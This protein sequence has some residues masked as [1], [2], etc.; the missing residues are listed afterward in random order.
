MLKRLLSQEIK[1]V[2]KRNI[3]AG[4]KFSEMLSA[5]LRRCQNRTLDTATLVA[6][7]VKLAQSLKSEADRG[8][9]SGLDQNELAFYDALRTNESAVSL[10]EDDT[11][12]TIAHELTETVRRDAK[13]DWTIKEQLRG[14]LRTTIKRLL[15]RHGYPPDKEP[16]ATELIV[17]QAEVMG[18]SQNQ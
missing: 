9:Q 8:V 15:L 14:K 10:M 7:L 1:A 4:K 5:S 17:R 12:K 11:M 18:E 2:S 13:T 3:V 16:A 6:E